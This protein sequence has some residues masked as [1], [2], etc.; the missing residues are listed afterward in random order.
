[1]K[2]A[3]PIEADNILGRL[4]VQFESCRTTWTAD[5]E[6]ALNDMIVQLATGKEYCHT[7][8]IYQWISGQPEFAQKSTNQIKSRIKSINKQ[9]KE[10]ALL[11]Q[12]VT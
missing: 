2:P 3:L 1:M 6:S 7:K 8:N 5:E 11:N 9:I 10:S 4:Q 12:L